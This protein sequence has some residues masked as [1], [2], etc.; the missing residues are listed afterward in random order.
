LRFDFLQLTQSGTPSSHFKWRSL[1]VKQPVRTLLG[2]LSATTA[3]EGSVI[4]SFFNFFFGFSTLRLDC[5]GG[6]G[7][8]LY[9]GLKCSL[10]RVWSEVEGE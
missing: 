7:G 3:P 10:G 6:G 1:H 9:V 4:D 8:G 2:L 5:G